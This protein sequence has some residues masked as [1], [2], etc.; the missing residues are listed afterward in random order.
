MESEVLEK[1]ERSNRRA[2]GSRRIESRKLLSRRT[3]N[4]LGTGK[5]E[6]LENE[7]KNK[8]TYKTVD[9]FLP[10]VKLGV[11]FTNILLAAFSYKSQTS[12]FSVLAVKV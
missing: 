11:N 12:S 10:F 4:E 7:N 8:I 3:K 9:I 6:R 2:N 5:L 1:E